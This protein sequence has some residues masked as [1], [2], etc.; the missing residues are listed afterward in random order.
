[1]YCDFWNLTQAPF[2]QQLDMEYFF[3]SEFHEE[4]LARLLFVADEQK[5]CAVFTGPSGTGKTLTL[6]VVEQFLKRSQHHCEYLDLLGWGE[7]EFLWQ[8]CSQLR[9]G[10]AHTTQLPQLWRQLT[11]YLTGYQLTQNRLILLLDHVDQ[12]HSECIKT[13]ERLIHTGNQRF[14]SLSIVTTLDHLNSG[15]TAAIAQL[16]DLSIELTPF[17]Q[18]TTEDYIRHRLGLSGC[19]KP[20]FTAEAFKK[21][22]QATKGI[23]KKINQICDLALLAGYEQNLQEIDSDVIARAGHEIKGTPHSTNRISEAIQGV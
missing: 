13:I 23:P 3:E 15:P 4:A 22:Y 5:K 2:H 12:C 18:E 7:E 16:S 11:D 21:V 20:V 17:D 19:A 1:M 8:L 10:P 6:R 9:L 14:P